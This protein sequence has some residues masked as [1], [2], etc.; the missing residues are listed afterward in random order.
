MTPSR[1]KKIVD[2]S[3]PNRSSQISRYIAN[4]NDASNIEQKHTSSMR[5]FS[6]PGQRYSSVMQIY[7]AFFHSI[8]DH[9]RAIINLQ[10]TIDIA[11]MIAYGFFADLHSTCDLF[12]NLS[13]GE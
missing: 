11:D 7:Q 13:P 8:N 4:C 2:T 5:R 6:H 3:S 9:L 1:S 12:G 10:F